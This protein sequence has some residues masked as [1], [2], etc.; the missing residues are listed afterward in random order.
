MEFFMH[1]IIIHLG[2]PS[3]DSELLESKNYVFLSLY[4]HCLAFVEWVVKQVDKR[5]DR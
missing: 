5:M 1:T 4:P 2:S 3:L